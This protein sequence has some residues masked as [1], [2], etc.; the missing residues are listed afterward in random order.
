M[1]LFDWTRD[2]LNMHYY[3]LETL[4]SIRDP[5]TKVMTKVFNRYPFNAFVLS[6]LNCCADNFLCIC[7]NMVFLPYLSPHHKPCLSIPQVHDVLWYFYLAVVK[8][9]VDPH[10]PDKFFK[11]PVEHLAEF[12]QHKERLPPEIKA[13]IPSFLFILRRGQKSVNIQQRLIRR[14]IDKRRQ[15]RKQAVSTIEDYWLAHI[16]NPDTRLG[17]K[18]VGALAQHFNT[19]A[20]NDLKASDT[21]VCNG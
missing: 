21:I 5:H 11:L 9:Y 19:L 18:R 7:L 6:M 10:C 15:V 8:G 2:C 3:I 13:F 4:S 1:M 16:Y 14:W 12:I 17:S 20:Q